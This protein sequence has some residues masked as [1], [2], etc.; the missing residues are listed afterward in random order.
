LPNARCDRAEV[1]KE[2]L[3]SLKTTGV[4]MRHLGLENDVDVR[5]SEASVVVPSH[6]RRHLGRQGVN[7]CSRFSYAEEKAGSEAIAD[8]GAQ[9]GRGIRPTCLTKRC[10][11]IE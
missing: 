8:G 5:D 1:L 10:R 9:D 2:L 4:G 3:A 7:L 6:L 11:L